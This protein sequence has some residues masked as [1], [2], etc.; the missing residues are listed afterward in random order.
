MLAPQCRGRNK[1]GCQFIGH[2]AE[3]RYA[4]SQWCSLSVHD[5]EICLTDFPNSFGCPRDLR[6]DS[7]FISFGEVF[8]ISELKLYGKLTKEL[9]SSRNRGRRRIRNY[10]IRN[11][12]GAILRRIQTAVR[13]LIFGCYCT[14]LELLSGDL[15][16]GQR[17]VVEFR[18]QHVLIVDCWI[19]VNPKC[20]ASETEVRVSQHAWLAKC[21]F[22]ASIE[23]NATTTYWSCTQSLVYSDTRARD[24]ECARDW[25]YE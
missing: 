16:I 5:G 12:G 6:S 25:R 10:M 14:L 24:C 1:I 9:F 17:Y 22:L 7:P 11:W 4:L 19:H 8:R 23:I 3:F 15:K 2:A 20:P 13:W 18:S 21:H